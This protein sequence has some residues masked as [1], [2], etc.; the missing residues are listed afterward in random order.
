MG[1]C[2]SKESTNVV[3]TKEAPVTTTATTTTVEQKQQATVSDN[4][5]PVAPAN[6]VKKEEKVVETPVVIP[7]PPTDFTAEIGFVIKSR[8]E[9]ENDEG[10]SAK[11]F[12][13]VFH[14]S[15]VLYILTNWKEKYTTD[16]SGGNTLTY[17]VVI[18]TAIFT[19]CS[20]SDES[21]E[22]VSE[23]IIDYLNTSL[24]NKLS[25]EFKIPRMKRGYVGDEIP[26]MKIPDPSII[27]TQRLITER[28]EEEITTVDDLQEEVGMAM[29][30]ENV[31]DVAAAAAVQK[32]E[33]QE[34]HTSPSR[35][36]TLDAVV[37]SEKKS[38]TRN[39]SSLN[40]HIIQAVVED[41]VARTSDGRSSGSVH[42]SDHV[43]AVAV[44]VSNSNS[45]GGGGSGGSDSGTPT[46]TH[47]T[48]H[49][50]NAPYKLA[51]LTF[52]GYA[53]KKSGSSFV[54]LQTRFFHLSEHGVVSYYQTK[55]DCERRS[56][57][58]GT[59]KLDDVDPQA[60]ATRGFSLIS[61]IDP[62]IISIPILENRSRRAYEIHCETTAQAASWA[63]SLMRHIA[64][65]DDNDD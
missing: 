26:T 20:A 16:K 55:E 33:H 46:S 34:I 22:Y 38:L 23:Q 7:P 17:D 28:P 6:I 44:P 57:P 51:P 37:E 62:L 61:A 12:V 53:L 45:R 13:N 11:V 65:N 40:S 31:H 54:G 63:D 29:T 8:I 14:H 59:I 19:R 21:K 25:Q 30:E 10:A 27:V 5:K 36:G 9:V 2:G 56:K 42:S 47:A 4:T 48:A 15:A 60:I 58:K 32:L 24:P 39:T 50:S 41:A 49:A 18:N 3:D 64:M 43:A 52:S 1:G 35:H